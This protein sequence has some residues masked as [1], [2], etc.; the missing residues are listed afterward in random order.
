MWKSLSPTHITEPA[1]IC[2][3]SGSAQG[4]PEMMRK[5]K[6]A[7]APAHSPPCRSQGLVTTFPNTKSFQEEQKSKYIER[8]CFQPVLINAHVLK[9]SSQVETYIQQVNAYFVLDTNYIFLD[10]HSSS[11]HHFAVENTAHILEFS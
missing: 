7:D 4:D 6:G 11:M 5:R 10:C 3:S 1:A 8:S 2:L 9:S